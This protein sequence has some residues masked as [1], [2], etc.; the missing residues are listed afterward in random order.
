MTEGYWALTLRESTGEIIPELWCVP[1]ISRAL[2]LELKLGLYGE[3]PPSNSTNNL[4]CGTVDL[5]SVSAT[6]QADWTFGIAGCV[7]SQ[8]TLLV[9]NIITTHTAKTSKKIFKIIHFNFIKVSKTYTR[10]SSSYVYLC[11][12]HF[13]DDQYKFRISNG[14]TESMYIHLFQI[15]NLMHNSF[16][17]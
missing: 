3:R 8:H 4:S 12:R 1:Q 13:L 6:F 15:T 17:L 2:S 5:V 9:P 10:V 11:V 7:S 16:I 14:C